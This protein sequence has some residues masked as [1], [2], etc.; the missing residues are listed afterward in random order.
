MRSFRDMNIRSTGGYSADG[1]AVSAI[2]V[3]I[4]EI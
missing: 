1:I 2:G 3:E 4:L